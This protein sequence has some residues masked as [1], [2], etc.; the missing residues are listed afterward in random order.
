MGRHLGAGYAESWAQDQHLAALDDRTVR[1]ALDQ[2]VAP[3]QVWRAVCSAL[4]LP[5]SEH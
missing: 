4:E 1:Q 5:P 3:K 2:G